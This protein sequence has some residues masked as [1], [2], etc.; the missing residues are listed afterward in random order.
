MKW[1]FIL[2][3]IYILFKHISLINH[4][5]SLEMKSNLCME[6]AGESLQNLA[7]WTGCNTPVWS[8][9]CTAAVFKEKYKIL[10]MIPWVIN[11]AWS[12]WYVR[13]CQS[14]EPTAAI[15]LGRHKSTV[16]FGTTPVPSIPLR[17]K[18]HQCHLICIQ[19]LIISHNLVCMAAWRVSAV[20]PIW[21][22]LSKR[23]LLR[24]HTIWNIFFF[25][26][27]RHPEALIL[28]LALVILD[29]SASAQVW[30]CA[31]LVLSLKNSAA[32]TGG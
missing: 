8:L 7:L 3:N 24:K 32:S 16:P 13:S 27:E 11:E 30:G 25:K 22:H 14:S 15:W 28:M 6:T 9:V 26:C 31:R 12:S 1:V 18:S 19:F 20:L 5:I 23:S 21:K 2:V 4:G 17:A 10:E 29:I